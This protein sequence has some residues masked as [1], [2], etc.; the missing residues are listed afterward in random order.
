MKK[1]LLFVF[2]LIYW[3]API[4]DSATT[5]GQVP[6]AIFENQTVFSVYPDLKS[7]TASVPLKSMPS[8]DLQ[9]LQSAA[10][11]S[12]VWDSPFRF[13]Y[14]FDVDYTLADG[15]WESNDNFK[16]W[17]LR[18]SSQGAY[19]L[20]FIF[21]TLH[22]AP[23]AKL[24]IFN[25]AGS[26]IYGPVTSV[27][28]SSGK[29]FLTSFIK[30]DE[31]VLQIIEPS[32]GFVSSEE[33]SLLRVSR[34]VHAYVDMF[35]NQDVSTTEDITI[36]PKPILSC[37]EDINCHPAWDTESD[38]VALA[39]TASGEHTCSGSLLNNTAGDYKP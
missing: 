28:N 21:D 17:S 19:S 24:Y 20:N 25:T 16:T 30:G 33:T 7:A 6:S 4:F 26:M 37:H 10:S 11:Q 31:V 2:A 9:A 8:V 15:I 34:V 22:L 12:N 5:F 39:I 35:P 13:G 36:T 32:S 14:G 3:L 29:H 18:I 27:Q 1:L 23:Q 38:A